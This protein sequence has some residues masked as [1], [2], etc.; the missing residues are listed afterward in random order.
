M[1]TY[2]LDPRTQEL[3]TWESPVYTETPPPAAKENKALVWRSNKWVYVTDYRGKEIFKQTAPSDIRIVTELGDLPEGYT[4]EVPPVEYAEWA[5]DHWSTTTSG[6]LAKVK[7]AVKLS[8]DEAAAEVYR[9]YSRFEMEYL[10][11]EAQARAYLADPLTDNVSFVASVATA[12]KITFEAASHM[13]VAEADAARAAMDKLQE[14]R[15][16]KLSVSDSDGTENMLLLQ[17]NVLAGIKEI[18]D[19]LE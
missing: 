7:A 18:G 16:L 13:I 5:G 14:L 3:V 2:A 19:L 17:K 11:R 1:T 15:M 8:I 10:T 12:A 6:A 4:T 9:K